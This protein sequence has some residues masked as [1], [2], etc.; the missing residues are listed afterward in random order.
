MGV[1]EPT[2]VLGDAEVGALEEFRRQD[3]LAALICG[4]ANKVLRLLHVF[5]Q[6]RPVG[7]LDHAEGQGSH[8]GSCC[9]MQW[10]EPPPVR[11]AREG[12]PI[13]SRSGKAS[14]K[15]SRANPEARSS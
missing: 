3:H 5:A 8:S 11:R 15:A 10:N 1:G 14:R 4:L 12:R 6:V 2:L 7:G 9:V 13:T